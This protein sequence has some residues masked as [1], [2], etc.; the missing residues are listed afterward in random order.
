MTVNYMRAPKPKLMRDIIKGMA[1]PELRFMVRSGALG[2]PLGIVLALALSAV[3]YAHLPLPAWLIVVAGAAVIGVVVNV[4]AI[5]VVFEPGEPRPRYRYLWRQG[6]FARRQHEAAAQLSEM[7]ATKVLT[8]ENFSNELLHGAYVERTLALIG[9]SVSVE[10]DRILGP[11][12]IVA[13]NSF[14]IIDVDA[15]GHG[16]GVAVREFAPILV[17][18][19]DFTREEARKIDTYAT[20]KLRSLTADEFGEMLYAAVERTRGCCTCTVRSWAS[21]SAPCTS[22][23]SAPELNLRGV[24]QPTAAPTR[25]PMV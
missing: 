12:K 23:S 4:I 14:G 13:R 25:L 16:A 22:S 17:S 3:H 24:G 11:F 20:A 19:G 5:K 18:D 6:L 1:V 21:S 10:V 7:L 9:L 8:V 2:L 15:I